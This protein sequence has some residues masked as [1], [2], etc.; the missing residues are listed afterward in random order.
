MILTLIPTNFS[1]TAQCVWAAQDAW[2]VVPLLCLQI[3]FSY[4][5]ARCMIKLY[6]STIFSC[7][8]SE[9]RLN[10]FVLYNI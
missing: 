5:L 3:Y 6:R 10:Q 1:L 4:Y 7:L 2:A 8:K 9:T